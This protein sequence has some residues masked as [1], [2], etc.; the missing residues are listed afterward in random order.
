MI[1]STVQQ[2]AGRRRHTALMTRSKLLLALLAL[3]LAPLAHADVSLDYADAQTGAAQTRISVAPERVRI[4]AAGLGSAYLVLDLRTQTL[5]QIDPRRRTTTSTTVAEVGALI[6]SL[7]N[8]QNAGNSPLLQLALGSLP[9]EQRAQTERVLAQARRDAAIPFTRSGER[10]EVDGI[11]CEVYVQRGAQNDLR[12]VCSA[13]VGA[14][15]L[16]NADART[17]DTALRLLRESGGPW[18]RAVQVPGIPLRYAGSFDGGAFSG[19]GQLT[20]RRYAPLPAT[21]F[22]D[23]PG[24][25][26]ASILE[27]LSNAVPPP[28]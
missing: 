15:G 4:D 12:R 9:P 21:H 14:L 5:T 19:S 26:I 24:Y 10:G 16:D 3:S 27:M 17:L 25:R 1:R 28:R 8:A 7:E 11:A 2:R 13:P 22:A 6:R 18:L 20:T 23:P